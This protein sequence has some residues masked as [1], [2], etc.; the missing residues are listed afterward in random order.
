MASP[1]SLP[2]YEF[3]IPKVVDKC[4]YIQGNVRHISPAGVYLDNEVL[5]FDYLVVATGCTYS[6]PFEVSKVDQSLNRRSEFEEEEEDVKSASIISPYSSKSI[7]NSYY[8]LTHSKKIVVV[9][10][11]FISILTILKED[12]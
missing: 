4:K 7:L 11:E 10:G 3:S 2:K 9:G 5:H 1:Q 6:I 8:N 12:Q